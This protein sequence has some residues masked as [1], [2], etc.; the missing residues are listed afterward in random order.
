MRQLRTAGTLCAV[1]LLSLAAALPGI[2]PAAA[3]E[4]PAFDFEADAQG[5]R[6]PD[7]AGGT[8]DVAH[9]EKDVKVGK[10]ALQWSYSG[11]GTPQIFRDG[12]ALKAGANSVDFWIKSSVN[13]CYQL[14]LIEGG[15][16]FYHHM[17]RTTADTWQHQRIAL[18]D[19]TLAYTKDA[20]GQLDLNQVQRIMLMD[21]RSFYTDAADVPQRTIWLDGLTFSG[22][23]VPQRRATR[24]VDGKLEVLLDDF[25]GEGLGWEAGVGS[26]LELAKDG[27]R[28]L[29]RATY[30]GRAT[31]K[32]LFNLSDHLDPRYGQMQALKM[33]VRASHAV[34]LHLVL[35]EYDNSF[36]GPRY[37]AVMRVPAGKEWTPI[38]VPISAFHALPGKEDANKHLDM[39]DVWLIN[40]T[41]VGSPDGAEKTELEIDSIAAVL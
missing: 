22:D 18:T 29:L 1:A 40:I 24:T 28:T 15:G 34:R 20:N 4:D 12:P 27:Q 23:V 21:T 2:R 38:S 14:I 8:L 37:E 32:D 3:V 39:P 31:S 19:F 41:D 7:G 33:V 36:E 30:D 25:D 26:K 17:I 5:W 35:M 10:G 16:G 11:G 6:M 9:A 13:G